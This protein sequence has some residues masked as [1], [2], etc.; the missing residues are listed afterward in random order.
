VDDVD[1]LYQSLADRGV[2]FVC[3]PQP[4]PWGY[5][6]E[7]LDP[8]GHAVRLWDEGSMNRQADSQATRRGDDS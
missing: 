5:G 6:A 1:R 7:L 3:A 4:N 8:D 2:A